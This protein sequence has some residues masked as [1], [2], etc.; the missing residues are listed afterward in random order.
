MVVVLVV[1]STSA[2][3]ED[4]QTQWHGFLYQRDVRSVS[5]LLEN[6]QA[7]FSRIG[8]ATD[9]EVWGRKDYWASPEELL[10]AGRGD[11]ED[12][13]IAKYY[14]LRLLGIPERDL[15]L[16]Y[17]KRLE[18]E[19]GRIEPHMV[20][21]Y[22]GDP[23]EPLVMDNQSAAVD[24]L[25]A[26]T[27]LVPEYGFNGQGLWVYRSG[28][29]VEWVG[30]STVLTAW[31]KLQERTALELLDAPLASTDVSVNPADGYRFTNVNL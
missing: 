15:R 16:V 27:D 21:L 13:A 30:E 28:V 9:R 31:R 1:M 3:A 6:V 18:R 4:L 19:S 11:C 24:P 29:G 7:F 26:R 8:N 5:R 22:Q 2:A 12:L 17:G 20:L 25:A 10:Q 14:T 23:R